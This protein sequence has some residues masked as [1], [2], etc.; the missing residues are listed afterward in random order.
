[1]GYESYLEQIQ[2]SYEEFKSQN[3]DREKKGSVKLEKLGLTEEELLKEQEALFEKA[4]QKFLAQQ[5]QQ[6]TQQQVSILDS[7]HPAIQDIDLRLSHHVHVHMEEG[8]R[9]VIKKE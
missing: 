8:E 1:M 7:I 4:R 3:K 2:T 6:Q 9:Q 5:Q